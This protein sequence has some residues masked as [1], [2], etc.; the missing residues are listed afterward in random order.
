MNDFLAQHSSSGLQ[1]TESSGVTWSPMSPLMVW[2][3][4]NNNLHY[5]IKR[6]RKTTTN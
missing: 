5:T 4:N 6:G 2:H 3:L 1:K